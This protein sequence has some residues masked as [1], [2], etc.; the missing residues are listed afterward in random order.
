MRL[1]HGDFSFNQWSLWPRPIRRYRIGHTFSVGLLEA[2][3][4]RAVLQK[5]KDQLESPEVIEK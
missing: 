3:A 2:V 1:G 5:R 4:Q